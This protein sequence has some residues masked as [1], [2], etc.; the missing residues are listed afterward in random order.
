M[1]SGKSDYAPFGNPSRE[2]HALPMKE[3]AEQRRR[4]LE[5]FIADTKLVVSAWE[6]DAKVGGG[7]LRKFLSGNTKSMTDRT[8]RALAYAAGQK[9]K[10]EVLV[11]E[12]LGTRAE[13]ANEFPVA[14]DVR[15]IDPSIPLPQGADMARDVPVFGTVPDGA[16]GLKMGVDDALDYVRRPSR[17]LERKGKPK[18]IFAVHVDGVAMR[19]KHAPGDL[20]YIDPLR[21]PHVGDSVLVEIK[22]D[23]GPHRV[24]LRR[25]AGRTETELRLEQYDPPGSMD[26]SLGHVVLLYRVMTTN[27]LLGF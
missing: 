2:V 10:R 23:E 27:D 21:G 19:P 5:K 17:F 3:D 7:A 26:V 13:P 11:T 16:G 15:R 20:L 9:L 1:S 8:Y 4:A 22:T 12:L 25:L 14:S 6:S 24:I 18:D